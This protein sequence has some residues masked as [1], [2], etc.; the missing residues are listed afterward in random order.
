ASTSASYTARLCVP[1]MPK[2]VVTFSDINARTN[3]SPP[4][5]LAAMKVSCCCTQR[6]FTNR[7]E[8]TS[9]SLSAKRKRTGR[10]SKFAGIVAVS[11]GPCPLEVIAV[12][13]GAFFQQ[14]PWDRFALGVLALD[15]NAPRRRRRA[16][17]C[18]MSALE[19]E[20]FGQQFTATQRSLHRD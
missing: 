13:F 12:F 1:G 19:N 15:T 9:A 20:R 18:K 16:V 7:N 2:T 8:K 17:Q 5:I 6:Y 14:K 11:P 3:A 4:V 10:P